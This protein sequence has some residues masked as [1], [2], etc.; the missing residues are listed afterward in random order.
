MVILSLQSLLKLNFHYLYNYELINYIKKLKE[1]IYTHI[2]N[3]YKCYNNEVLLYVKLM[4]NY[5]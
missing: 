2:L 5:V 1:Y 3:H 4:N